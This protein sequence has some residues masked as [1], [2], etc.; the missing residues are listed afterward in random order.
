MIHSVVCHLFC[1]KKAAV[2]GSHLEV[3]ILHIRTYLAIVVEHFQHGVAYTK[4]MALAMPISKIDKKRPNWVEYKRDDETYLWP[5]IIYTDFEEF[6]G[7]VQDEA[8]D[9]LQTKICLALFDNKKK[10]SAMVAR[11]LGRCDFLILEHSETYWRYDLRL[12]EMLAKAIPQYFIKHLDL[13]L[14]FMSALDASY[15]WLMDD[16]IKSDTRRREGEEL[17]AQYNKNNDTIQQ[18]DGNKTHEDEEQ[19]QSSLEEKSP[20]A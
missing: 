14:D 11:L 8:D 19:Q 12:F 15:D 13:Y 20:A 9:E 16:G 4:A 18:H 3:H 5:A 7:H 17:L 2:K 6:R 1:R 10:G